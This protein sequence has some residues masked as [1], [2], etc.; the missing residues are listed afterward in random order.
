MN[1]DILFPVFALIV[2][3]LT[4]FIWMYALRIPAMNKM[5]ISPE[6]AKHARTLKGMLPSKVEAVSD[7]YSH[8][9][10]QPTIFYALCFYLAV[11]GHADTLHLQLAWGYVALRVLHSLIQNTGNN[12]MARFS[13][14]SLSTILLM[15]MAAR[16]TV[17][18]ITYAG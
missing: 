3:T 16:E 6:D 18:L 9:M 5:N 14:F 12:V 2:W 8:L 10:E 13:V 7:N 15:V 17:S 1:S 11:S 4:V